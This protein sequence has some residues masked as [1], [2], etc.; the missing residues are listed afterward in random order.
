MPLVRVGRIMHEDHRH[1]QETWQ[2]DLASCVLTLYAS[3][4]TSHI[5]Q[6]GCFRAVKRVFFAGLLRVNKRGYN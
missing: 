5:P 6:S 2:S 3:P 1:F 4:F